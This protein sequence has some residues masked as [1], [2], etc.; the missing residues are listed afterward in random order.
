MT[1]P[2]DHRD[3]RHHVQRLDSKNREERAERRAALARKLPD[4]EAA[5]HDGPWQLGF[6]LRFTLQLAFWSW[7]L[8]WLAGQPEIPIKWL[9]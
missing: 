3:Y 4:P 1:T 8:W 2:F 5:P 6:L 9:Q 7:L